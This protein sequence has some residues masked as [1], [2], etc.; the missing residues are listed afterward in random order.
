M[1]S[2]SNESALKWA[3]EFSV[4]NP[5][6]TIGVFAVL[7][8]LLFLSIITLKVGIGVLLFLFL[9]FLVLSVQLFVGDYVAKYKDEEV[10]KQNICNVQLNNILFDKFPIA[11]GSFIGLFVV[12]I[13]ISIA[14]GILYFIFKLFGVFGYFLFGII[15]ITI[16]L[17]FLYIMP[18]VFGEILKSNSFGEAF[19]KAFLYFNVKF[20]SKTFNQNYMFF[21]FVWMMVESGVSSLI[22]SLSTFLGVVVFGAVFASYFASAFGGYYNNMLVYTNPGFSFGFIVALIIYSIAVGIMLYYLLLYN[23]IIY[24]YAAQKTLQPQ[25]EAE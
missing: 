25:S 1:I 15:S 13:G 10:L 16:G 11:M 22:A 14:A 5:K 17:I 7:G 24:A 21:V 12:G 4:L 19:N 18:A 2:K 3:W 23:G 8:L 20:W 6:L 9:A